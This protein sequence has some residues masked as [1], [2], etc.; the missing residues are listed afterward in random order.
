MTVSPAPQPT[1]N[2]VLA[3]AATLAGCQPVE[4]L[5]VWL[6]GAE[7]KIV[8]IGGTQFTFDPAAI[9]AQAGAEA[10]QAVIDQLG[11]LTPA[12]KTKAKKA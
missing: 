6:Q 3:I 8:T 5:E 1:G 10:Y 7:L 2:E 12:A 4:L 11:G 9:I